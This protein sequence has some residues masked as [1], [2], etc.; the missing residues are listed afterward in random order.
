[1]SE[2]WIFEDSWAR[3]LIIPGAVTAQAHAHT[4]AAPSSYWNHRSSP[5]TSTGGCLGLPITS[6]TDI[7]RLPKILENVEYNNPPNQNYN[8]R[9]GIYTREERKVLISRFHEKRKRRVWKKKIRY[10]CRKNLAE[11]R[12]RIKVL[13]SRWL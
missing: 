6:E 1:M 3:P 7:N 12:V 5:S 10:H 13:K 9:I 2:P 4:H 11:R 8:G